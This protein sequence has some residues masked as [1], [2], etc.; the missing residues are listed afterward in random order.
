MRRI[1]A[2]SSLSTLPL[3]EVFR[4]TMGKCAEVCKE[5]V[6]VFHS[7]SKCRDQIEGRELVYMRV[8]L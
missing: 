1:D 6:I 7:V 4:A 8:L 2:V 5:T 3:V